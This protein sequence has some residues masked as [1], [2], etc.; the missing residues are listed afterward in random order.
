MGSIFIDTLNGKSSSRPP[1]WFMRQAGRI[2][3]SYRAL[4]K[5][6]TFNELMRDKTLASKVTLLPINDLKVDAAI[7]FSDILIVPESLGLELEFTNLGPKFHN[8]VN[9]DTDLVIDYS[10]FDHVYDNIKEVIKNKPKDIPLIGFCGGPLTTFLF[11]FRGNEKNKSFDTAINF[12]KKEKKKSMK[13]MEMLTEASIEYVK[14]QVKSG[15]DCFQLFE[16]YSGIISNEDYYKLI[17]PL[18]TKILL[19][20]RES[21]VPTIFFPKDYSLGLKNINNSICDFVSV[22]WH[23]SLPEARK[24]VDNGV[25]LQGNMDP[26]IFYYEFDTIKKYLNSLNEFGSKN[27]NWIFNL[28]HG[29][30]PDIDHL[31]VKKT[32]QWIKKNNWNR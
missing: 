13:I 17:L 18:S 5:N 8:P 10:N 14:N 20:A 4:K 25:G 22:D 15:I 7:L 11:M 27:S 23:I 2:L 28:G 21:G 30:L 32:V 12:F 19:E 24:L 3:P 6:Y 26:R 9:V 16:T 31:K 1:V 29:F